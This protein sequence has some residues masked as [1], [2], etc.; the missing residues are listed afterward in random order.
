MDEDYGVR[1]NAT[2]S[3][4]EEFKSS[5]LWNDICHELDFW[6]EGFNNEESSIVDKVINE[7]LS[8]A[9]TLTLM[10]DLDGRKKTVM[11]IKGILDVFLSMI[12][13]KNNDTRHNETE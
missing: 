13:E 3:Q 8:T 1:I 12:E 7:N 6:V 11:Y 4:I 9:A 2:K 5:V 10:G